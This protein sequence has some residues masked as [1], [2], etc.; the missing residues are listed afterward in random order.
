MLPKLSF[1]RKLTI[2]LVLLALSNIALLSFIGYSL[3]NHK[4]ELSSQAK[5]L[6]KDIGT[7]TS[8]ADGYSCKEEA[9]ACLE[10]SN[11]KLAINENDRIARCHRARAYTFLN[12]HEEAL[13]DINKLIALDEKN[14]EWYDMKAE[15]LS[16]LNRDAEA[17]SALNQAIAIAPK[18]DRY[19]GFY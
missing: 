13:K 16:N 15:A 6:L 7:N 10:D 8:S 19:L 18:V 4:R 2:F 3:N 1:A 9:K 12:M 5:K 14:P 17:I 11:Q